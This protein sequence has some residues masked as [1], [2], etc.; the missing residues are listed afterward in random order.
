MALL[1]AARK[2]F[3]ALP[4]RANRRLALLVF[5][6][7]FVVGGVIGTNLV[8]LT[9]RDPRGPALDPPGLRGAADPSRGG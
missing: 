6:L 4:D 2:E 1:V 3:Y 9:D 8:F 5:S 7:L